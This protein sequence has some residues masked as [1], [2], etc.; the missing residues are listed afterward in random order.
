[1]TNGNDKAFPAGD[2]SMTQPSGGLTIREHFAGLAMQGL[3]ATGQ[4]SEYNNGS[5]TSGSYNKGD[6]HKLAVA[7]ADRLI[8]QLNKEPQ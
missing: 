1:M 5:L 8:A 4:F 7:N 6:V 3:L 2:Q